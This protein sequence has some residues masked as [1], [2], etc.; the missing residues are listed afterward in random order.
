MSAAASLCGNIVDRQ[1]PRSQIQN[2]GHIPLEVEVEIDE[3][4]IPGL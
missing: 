1:A 3:I 2:L 4:A